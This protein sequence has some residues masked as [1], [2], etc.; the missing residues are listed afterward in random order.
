LYLLP[1]SQARPGLQSKGTWGLMFEVSKSLFSGVLQE[2]TIF[3]LPE[4]TQTTWGLITSIA[5]T[6]Y[7]YKAGFHATHI[8]NLDHG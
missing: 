1:S 3:F 4:Y 7:W 5:L 8:F 2:N 6:R